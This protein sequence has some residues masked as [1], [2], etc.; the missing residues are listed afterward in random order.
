VAT[1]VWFAH[2]ATTA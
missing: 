2:S 1:V